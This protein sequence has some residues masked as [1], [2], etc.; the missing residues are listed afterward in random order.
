MARLQVFS[1]D[2]IDTLGSSVSEGKGALPNEH[3]ADCYYCRLSALDFVIRWLKSVEP[4]LPVGH[5][6]LLRVRVMPHLRLFNKACCRGV[7][8]RGESESEGDDLRVRRLVSM[9]INDYRIPAFQNKVIGL[10]PKLV[11]VVEFMLRYFTDELPKSRAFPGTTARLLHI[12][13]LL[14][15]IIVAP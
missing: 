5:R 15:I 2:S 3:M 8:E 10:E 6:A 1:I 11:E 14:H 7:S 13:C 12:S 4:S 9:C